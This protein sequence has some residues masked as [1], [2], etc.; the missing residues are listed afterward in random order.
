VA[1]Q[2]K[3]AQPKSLEQRLWDAADA[4]RGNGEPS[5]YKHVVLGLVFLKHVSDDFE[6]K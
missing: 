5:E 3:K 6:A 1:R 2:A 4:L